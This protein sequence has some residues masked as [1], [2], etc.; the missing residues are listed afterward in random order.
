MID[1]NELEQP[2]PAEGQAEQARL[3]LIPLTERMPD[4]DKHHRVVV[5]TE[6]VD[7]A[8]Q[9]F[10]DVEAESLNE[11]RYA[12][13]ADQ[14]EV[15]RYATH[16][17]GADDLA[18]MASA[19]CH[20]TPAEGQAR[21]T[22]EPH[23]T[24]ITAGDAGYRVAERY[25]GALRQL[26]E[27]EKS[28]GQAF[29]VELAA[30]PYQR[31]GD[32]YLDWMIEGGK[33]ALEG[34]ALYVIPDMPIPENGSTRLRALASQPAGEWTDRQCLEFMS[35]ALRHVEYADGSDVPTCDDIR[36]GVRFALAAQQQEKGN[37]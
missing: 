33:D 24:K 29:S 30:I 4:P 35:V 23:P 18:G 19:L 37:E 22:M 36:L 26:A 14:P 20:P 6:G 16:W 10:F 13:P 31:G 3:R 8:G 28:E 5:Y 9:Q 15:C 12:D 2:T 27:I 34:A 21:P 1:T 25:G 7:F 17:I 11:N 32:T